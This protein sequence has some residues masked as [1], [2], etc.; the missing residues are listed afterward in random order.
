MAVSLHWQSFLINVSSVLVS[1]SCD[2]VVAYEINIESV[3]GPM[4]TLP[5]NRKEK[6]K[7][8]DYKNNFRN[9]VYFEYSLGNGQ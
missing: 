1:S 4:T 9:D 7:K 8:N 5:Q 3:L 2:D 6:N